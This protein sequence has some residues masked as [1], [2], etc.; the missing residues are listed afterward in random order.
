MIYKPDPA[1]YRPHPGFPTNIRDGDLILDDDGTKFYQVGNLIYKLYNS[2]SSVHRIVL[3]RCP[4][5]PDVV[6]GANHKNREDHFFDDHSPEDF[7]LGYSNPENRLFQ[8]T[9]DRSVDADERGVSA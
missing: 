5:C 3:W 8:K 7:G 9:G 4:L 1:E 6:F 2:K